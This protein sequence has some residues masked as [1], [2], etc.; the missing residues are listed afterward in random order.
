MSARPPPPTLPQLEPF[1]PHWEKTKDLIDQ[2][3]DIMLNQSESGHPGGSRSKVHGAIVTLLS[4]IMRWDIRDPGKPFAD[5]FLLAAGHTCPMIY[6]ALAVFN[7]A[8]RIK[9]QQTGDERYVVPKAEE[10]QLTWED[11]L[12]LR[13]IGGL[14]GHAE[15]SG[16]T[17]LFKFNTGPS[18][19]GFASA[20]GQALALKMAGLD[21]VRVFGIEGEGGLTAGAVH[22]AKNT[23]WGLGLD[24]LLF[25]IDWNDFGIDDRAYSEVVSGEPR[26]WFDPYGWY[27]SGTMEGSNWQSVTRSYLNLFAPDAPSAPKVFWSRNRKGRGYHIFDQKS[28]G[29]PHKH[30][31]ENFWKGRKDFEDTYGVEF[32]DHGAPA[33]STY[34]GQLAQTE[35]YLRTVMEVLAEDQELVDY[36]ADTLVALGDAVPNQ[37]ESFRLSEGNPLDDPAI[38]DYANYPADLFM[39]VGYRAPNRAGLARWGAWVNSYC[40][41]KYDR[42]LFIAAA[43]DVADS[44]NISGFAKGFGD[45][46]GWDWYHRDSNPTG[47][48]LPQPITEFANA[49]LMAGL[50]CVNMSPSPEESFLG[51]LGACSTYSSFSYLKYGPLRLLSQIAQ[52]SE[53]KLGRVLWIASHSGP[54]TA[55]DGR[56]HFGIFAPGVTSLFPRGHIINLHPW[57]HNEVPVVLAAAL[58]TEVPLIAIHLSRPP[59]EIPDREGLGMDPHW[60][61]AK[62]AYLIRDFDPKRPRE[63]TV[64]IRGASSTNNLVSLLPRLEKEGPNLKIVSAI[65][66]ELF[67]LQTPEYRQR[68]LSDSDLADSMVIT[69]GS[70]DNMANW[71]GHP[72]VRQ[73]S[74]SSDWDDGWR[75]GGKG[76]EM[77]A[78]ARLDPDSIW[79][80]IT[81][82]A[83]ERKERMARLR[84]AVQEE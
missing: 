49:S 57:E 56:T 8:L 72:L 24:N 51:Y 31:S 46:D 84:A 12:T 18:G 81:R 26:D 27:T 38:T 68:V 48:L 5:R 1:F 4:G 28:H 15:M 17:L 55:E 64:I 73:Y 44:T 78:E 35:S 33:A 45:F 62:G 36:L 65:S 34:E 54:E 21:E 3:I 23:A 2:C 25:Y 42:P 61:A 9:H 30:N 59:F 69:S 20:V 37:I 82:F 77:V 39:P 76:D 40:A 58:A 29:A 75:S 22:E 13:H 10:R 74:L 6:G 43:A 47:C 19:H 16:K 67:Q 11:L 41:N 66:F 60:E 32:E 50:A 71:I 83:A 7:E 70:L 53:L 80:G 14:S 79:E 52:D 63:G